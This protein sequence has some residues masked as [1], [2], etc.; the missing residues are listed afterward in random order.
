MGLFGLAAIFIFIMSINIGVLAQ[1]VAMILIL[2]IVVIAILAQTVVLI[3]IY[4]QTL[5]K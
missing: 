2:L 3:K 4:E 5:K 1:D